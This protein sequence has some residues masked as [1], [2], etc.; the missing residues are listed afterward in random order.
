MSMWLHEF[1]FSPAAL[2]RSI[3]L[4]LLVVSLAMPTIGL[5]R[6]FVLAA[7]VI[8]FILSAIF[9]QNPVDLFWWALLAAVVLVRMVMARGAGFGG[10]LGPEERLFHKE[11]VPTLSAG[12]VRQLL[13]AG[14]WRDVVAGT[15]LTRTG[16]PVGEL[17]FVT[18]GQVDI[19]VDGKRVA[20]CGPGSLIGEIGMSTGEPA[21]AT[22]VCATP[23][24]YLGFEAKR[25]YRLLDS[26]VVLQDAIELAIERSLRDKLNRSNLAAA[27]AGEEIGGG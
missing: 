11:V 16:Q 15:I 8:G 5:V 18:R 7:A 3:G 27:H 10:H 21:T 26:H 25:L 22:A 24:R 23:V 6:I 20:E 14:R 17:C 12:Q 2:A 1:F 19:V 13:T 9:V 4:F